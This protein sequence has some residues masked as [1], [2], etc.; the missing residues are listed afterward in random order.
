VPALCSSAFSV[1]TLLKR[2]QQA[3]RFE[4][5]DEALGVQQVV[6]QANKAAPKGRS[7]QSLLQAPIQARAL[8]LVG[9]VPYGR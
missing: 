1:Q 7:L 3:R 6:Q 5:E 9:R 8:V 4:D 2:R